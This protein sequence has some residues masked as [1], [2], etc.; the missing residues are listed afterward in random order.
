[1]GI[2]NRITGTMKTCLGKEVELVEVKIQKTNM[3]QT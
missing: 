1:M 3:N 2:L